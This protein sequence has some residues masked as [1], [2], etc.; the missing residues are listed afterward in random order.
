MSNKKRITCT[1]KR[2]DGKSMEM[3][4]AT[5]VSFCTLFIALTCV[6]TAHADAGQES[7]QFPSETAKLKA[8]RKV[9]RQHTFVPTLPPEH[10]YCTQL[11][12]DFLADRHIKA[13]EPD[14]RADDENDPRLA[15][16]HRCDDVSIDDMKVTDPKLGYDSIQLLG[17]PPYRYYRIDIDGHP[18]N[19]K[20]DVLYAEAGPEVRGDTGYY[21]VD[22]QGCGIRGG[23]GTNSVYIHKDASNQNLYRLNMLA[24][25]RGVPLEV[26][27]YSIGTN[28]KIQFMRFDK[29]QRPLL[30]AWHQS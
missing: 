13:I 14:V 23:A 30:C 17:G 2:H 11:F 7:H 16:W 6:V 1:G 3:N 19:G 10:E 4:R 8:I 18:E 15:K 28:Y 24:A 20:E 9:V 27:L 12:K 21:W 25:Y 22:L 5:R 29:Q 26:E